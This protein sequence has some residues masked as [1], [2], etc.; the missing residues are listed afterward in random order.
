ML[1]HGL[2]VL[3]ERNL[4]PG[5]KSVNLPFCEHY[6]MSKQHRLKFNRST[7]RS[8]YMLDLIHSYVWESPE[9]SLGGAKYAVSFIDDYSKRLWMYSIK[10]KSDVFQ[11][12]KDFKARVELE[13]G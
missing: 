1:E 5:L 8:K 13:S 6:V 12:F 7:A 10:K 11:I 3:V 4:I 9:M 2:K